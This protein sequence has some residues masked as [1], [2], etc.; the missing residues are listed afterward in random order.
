MGTHWNTQ[1]HLVYIKEYGTHFTPIYVKHSC[2][3]YLDIDLIVNGGK[4]PVQ[5][6]YLPSQLCIDHS[7][8]ALLYCF[9]CNMMRHSHLC[10]PLPEDR[11]AKRERGGVGC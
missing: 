4:L 9:L 8:A 3:S 6:P 11:V 2:V 5:V 10:L 7:D 1:R